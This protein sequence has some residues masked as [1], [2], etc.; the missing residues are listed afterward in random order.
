VAQDVGP[1]FRSQYHTHKKKY[2]TQK[3]TGGVAQVVE[4]LSSKHETLN[5]NSVQPKKKIAIMSG[6]K[7]VIKDREPQRC[8]VLPNMIR[9]GSLTT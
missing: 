5:S 8:S 4:R 2:L 6:N 3:R 7:G 9:E 1:E